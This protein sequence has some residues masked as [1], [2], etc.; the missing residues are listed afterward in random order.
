MRPN[1]A[2]NIA[3]T[4][5]FYCRSCDITGGIILTSCK[6]QEGCF[7]SQCLIKLSRKVSRSKRCF[8]HV[9]ILCVTLEPHIQSTLITADFKRDLLVPLCA[10]SSTL[11]MRSGR[12]SRHL[13]PVYQNNRVFLYQKK[14]VAALPFHAGYK[15]HAIVILLSLC[16]IRNHYPTFN[17]YCLRYY[18]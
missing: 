6:L 10:F 2:P 4:I 8:Q 15:K 1:S 16:Y 3:F 18:I 13:V 9:F 7:S 5:E 12:L 11:G 17:S 14:T